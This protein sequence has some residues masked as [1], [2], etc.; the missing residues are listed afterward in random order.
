MPTLDELQAQRAA[1]ELQIAQASIDALEA[2]QAV[3]ASDTKAAFLDALNDTLSGMAANSAAANGLTNLLSI[4]SVTQRMIDGEATR[5]RAII[6][7]AAEP[8]E[9]T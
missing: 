8:G 5:T 4:I 2:A 3:F 9:A 7:A 6:D 1:I